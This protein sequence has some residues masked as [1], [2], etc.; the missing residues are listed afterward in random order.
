[1][2]GLWPLAPDHKTDVA[3]SSSTAHYRGTGG[4]KIDAARNCRPATDG[5]LQPR[6]SGRRMGGDTAGLTQA[7]LCATGSPAGRNGGARERHPGAG[8]RKFADAVRPRHSWGTVGV[9]P[10]EEK[11]SCQISAFPLR[12]KV[13]RKRRLLVFRLDRIRQFFK[14]FRRIA[15]QQARL[16]QLLEAG[17]IAQ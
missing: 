4:M 7:T 9:C 15:V 6:T 14:A 1:M 13:I 5:G 8:E 10:A 16:A 3:A 12:A 11:V 17:K 2:I